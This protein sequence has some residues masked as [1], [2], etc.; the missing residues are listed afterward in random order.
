M[1]ARQATRVTI[2]EPDHQVMLDELRTRPVPPEDED[3]HGTRDELITTYPDMTTRSTA[4]AYQQIPDSTC[5]TWTTR[6]S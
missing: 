3:P 5:P 2:P 4:P 6:T 1:E